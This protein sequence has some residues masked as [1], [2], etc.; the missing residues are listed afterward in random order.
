MNADHIQAN[1]AQNASTYDQFASLPLGK[2]EQQL[3]DLSIKDCAGL[4]VLDLGGGTGARARDA[5]KAGAEAVD[6]VDISPEMM[7]LG[8]AQEASLGRERIRWFHGDASQSLDHLGLA[9]YDLVIANGVFDHA[10]NVEELDMMWR[11]AAA[12]LKP[13]GRVLANRNNPYSRAASSGKY[14]VQLGGFQPFAGGFAYRYRMLTEP[15]LEFESLALDAYYDGSMEVAGKYFEAFTNVRWEETP[16]VRGDR[17]FWEEYLQ[18]PIL[19]IF[20]ATKRHETTA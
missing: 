4:K 5:L 19:Y 8:Q 11:N 12:Y 9:P 1:Y 20:T 17:E 14:G 18:D 7:Q 10:H 16:V 15:V 6:V 3:F 2:L 13:G